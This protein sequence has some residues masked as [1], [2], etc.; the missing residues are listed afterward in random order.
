LNFEDRVPTYDEDYNLLENDYQITQFKTTTI[1]FSPSWITGV[2]VHTSPFSNFDATI[3]IK[4][5][6]RQY[7]DNTQNKSRSINPYVYGDIQLIYSIPL[8]KSSSIDL[9]LNINNFWNARYESNGYTYRERYAD[10]T[11]GFTDAVSYNAYY[12]QAG[13]HASGGINV[14]F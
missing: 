2:S 6:S 10:G 4:Q 14:K 9:L 3:F 11:G 7:L 5:V 13:I 8:V 1:A 12:P